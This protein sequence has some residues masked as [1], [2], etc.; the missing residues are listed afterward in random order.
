MRKLL[1]ALFTLL[2][3]AMAHE[4]MAQN[5]HSDQDKARVEE[6]SMEAK[7]A[8]AQKDNEGNPSTRADARCA[9]KTGNERH[10][11]MERK[12]RGKHH[13]DATAEEHDEA[14]E[15]DDDDDDDDDGEAHHHEHK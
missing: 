15:H 5:V 1:I 11:C 10:E 12:G 6:R 3:S 2:A 7:E 8:G 9:G 4:S 13:D 14:V